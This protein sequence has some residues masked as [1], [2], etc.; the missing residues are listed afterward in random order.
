MVQS[1]ESY[2]AT[3]GN[4]GEITDAWVHDIESYGS[5]SLLSIHLVVTADIKQIDFMLRDH[6]GQGKTIT[7]G[8]ADCLNTLQPAIKVMVSKMR[9]KRVALQ[10]TE[11]CCELLPQVR[12]LLEKLAGRTSEAGCPHKGVHASTC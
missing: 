4:K 5:V 2:H 3:H 10:I 6:K 9:L 1:Q 8:D 7:G 11:N 12:M